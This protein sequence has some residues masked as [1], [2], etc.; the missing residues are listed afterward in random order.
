MNE[1]RVKGKVKEVEG[2]SQQTW[3]KVKDK[4]EIWEQNQAPNYYFLILDSCLI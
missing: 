2:E 3:G 1:D 4:Q